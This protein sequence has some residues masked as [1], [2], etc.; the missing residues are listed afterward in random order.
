MDRHLEALAAPVC[1][2][3]KADVSLLQ[4]GLQDEVPPAF[5]NPLTFVVIFPDEQRGMPVL[6]ASLQP[7]AERHFFEW[8]TRRSV[9]CREILIRKTACQS[10]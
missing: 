10:R 6:L 1:Q 7:K 3:D 9:F 5:E 8:E 2:F 4:S